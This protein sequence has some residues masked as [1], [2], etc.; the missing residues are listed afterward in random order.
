MIER[1]RKKKIEKRQAEEEKAM[2]DIRRKME[3]I[4]EQRIQKHRQKYDNHYQGMETGMVGE[5]LGKPRISE[6]G[7]IGSGHP[8]RKMQAAGYIYDREVESLLTINTALVPNF[9]ILVLMRVFVVLVSNTLT[10]LTVMPHF[11]SFVSL[12]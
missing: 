6:I 7:W 10:R 3:R 8:L 5:G 9:A 4:K 11:S 12:I 2:A 1:E